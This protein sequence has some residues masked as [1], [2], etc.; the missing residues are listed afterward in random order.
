MKMN[1][2][3]FFRFYEK[4]IEAMTEERIYKQW[5]IQLPNMTKENYEPYSEYYEKM[6]QKNVDKR[7]A[8]EIIH[9]IEMAH[10]KE[11]S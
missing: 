5:V 3:D 1:V 8:E 11:I 10:N 6:T 7:S 9:E 4:A 2:L